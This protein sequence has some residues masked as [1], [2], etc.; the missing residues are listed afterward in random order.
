MYVETELLGRGDPVASESG[1]EIAF[2]EEVAVH[3]RLD[4]QEL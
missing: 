3:I 2:L 1:S 4:A